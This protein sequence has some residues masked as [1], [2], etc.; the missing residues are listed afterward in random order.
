M[1]K[2]TKIDLKAVS[3]GLGIDPKILT[4]LDGVIK[5]VQYDIPPTMAKELLIKFWAYKSMLTEWI[6]KATKYERECK[7]R[8]K[9]EFARCKTVSPESSEAAKTRWA[10]EQ[11]SYQE[12]DTEAAGASIFREHLLMK[13][14][15]L[16][17]GHYMCKVLLG[18]LKE[19]WSM[20]PDSKRDF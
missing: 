16:R 11:P 2:E 6:T 5:E 19:D 1:A 10:E 4:E 7:L 3:S 9:Q 13:R 20:S 15:D 14:E 17:E 12:A 18:S 8:S